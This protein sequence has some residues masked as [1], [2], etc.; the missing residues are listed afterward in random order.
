MVEKERGEAIEKPEGFIG[1]GIG[2]VR[3]QADRRWDRHSRGSFT[4]VL[5]RDRFLRVGAREDKWNQRRRP[6]QHS[7]DS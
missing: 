7:R 6:T 5:G 3:V 2:R 1:A 4:L